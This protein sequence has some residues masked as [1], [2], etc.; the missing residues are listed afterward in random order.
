MDAGGSCSRPDSRRVVSRE[1]VDE[2]SVGNRELVISRSIIDVGLML[3]FSILRGQLPTLPRQEGAAAGDAQ[4]HVWAR[5]AL[6]N[7][8]TS[9]A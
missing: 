6:R 3:M 7:N 1:Q 8:P 5:M 9:P 2:H 4:S